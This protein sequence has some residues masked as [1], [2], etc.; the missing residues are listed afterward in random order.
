MFALA[1]GKNTWW[2]GRAGER[3]EEPSC[4]PSSLWH[5]L[6][7]PEHHPVSGLSPQETPRTDPSHVHVFFCQCALSRQLS[8]SSCPA[9]K[10]STD[11]LVLTSRR[12]FSSGPSQSQLHHFPQLCIPP[13]HANLSS[14][15]LARKCFQGTVKL[16]QKDTIRPTLFLQV[17]TLHY[18][19]YWLNWKSIK[20]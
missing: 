8:A 9:G 13:Y 11:L 1:N 19:P 3:L 17:Q 4:R 5:I 12:Q 7:V 2:W 14:R 20:P 6:R 10:V 16:V 18:R 15:A